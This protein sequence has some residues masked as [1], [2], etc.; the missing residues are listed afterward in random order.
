MSKWAWLWNLLRCHWGIYCTPALAPRV[1]RHGR[2]GSACRSAV[3]VSVRLVAR[4]NRE[5]APLMAC[6]WCS[7][8]TGGSLP[9]DYPRGDMPCCSR[10]GG[11]DVGQGTDL[12]RD[13]RTRRRRCSVGPEL[14]LDVRMRFRFPRESELPLST[15]MSN[16][17]PERTP[18]RPGVCGQSRIRI[19][20]TAGFQKSRAGVSNGRRL[21]SDSG[22]KCGLDR[23][24]QQALAGEVQVHQVVHLLEP[25]CDLVLLAP[26]T[27]DY[28]HRSV[29]AL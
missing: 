15:N 22:P 29:R 3:G 24:S 20:A 7:G 14:K 23:F 10:K 6:E 5:R 9:R 16:M 4:R 17:F 11:E 13:A 18:I 26:P 25:L 12:P 2:S 21:T 28:P 27:H 19:T 1:A 8:R